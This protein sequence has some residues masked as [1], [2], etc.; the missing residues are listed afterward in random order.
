MRA[1]TRLGFCCSAVSTHDCSTL[2]DGK[3][4]RHAFAGPGETGHRHRA[5]RRFRAVVLRRW[6]GPLGADLRGHRLVV[7][8]L[9]LLHV[10]D[11]DQAHLE[12]LL[13]LFQ[14]PG[15]GGARW[16]FA[17]S[18]RPAR[19]VPRNRPGTVRSMDSWR[20]AS[21]SASPCASTSFD[22]PSGDDGA[23]VEHGL[24]KRQSPTAVDVASE[25]AGFDDRR[26]FACGRGRVEQE[27]ARLSLAGVSCRRR[28][29]P[30]TGNCGPGTGLPGPPSGGLRPR[31]ACGSPVRARWYTSSRLSDDPGRGAAESG[32]RAWRKAMNFFIGN[33]PPTS[34]CGF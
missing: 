4:Q 29:F 9:G 1:E 14:L 22:A 7:R 25:R 32:P 2:G 12:T 33:R 30:G 8:G 27:G 34:T 10:G 16:R 21:K 24:G 23:P 5:I 18:V 11:G 20:A 6:P 17:R 3:R 26:K 13:R 15:D 31:A 19:P 28:R